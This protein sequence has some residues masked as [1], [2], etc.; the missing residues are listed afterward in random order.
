LVGSIA[1]EAIFS[2][3]VFVLFSGR[4]CPTFERFAKRLA[5]GKYDR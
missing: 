4:A 3:I 2:A 1:E 5:S